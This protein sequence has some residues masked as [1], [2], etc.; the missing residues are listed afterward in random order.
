[1]IQ[2]IMM[3]L[4]ATLLTVAVLKAVGGDEEWGEIPNHDDPV[5]VW[6]SS[7][8]CGLIAAVSYLIVNYV[9]TM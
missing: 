4:I 3:F 6:G 7:L 8:V 9:S 2:A 5:E 1:M